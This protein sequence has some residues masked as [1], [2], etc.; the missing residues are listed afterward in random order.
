MRRKPTHTPAYPIPFTDSDDFPDLP[1]ARADYIVDILDRAVHDRIWHGKTESAYQKYDRTW[2]RWLE[3]LEFLG[4]GNDPFMDNL[5]YQRT[6]SAIVE[7]FLIRMRLAEFTTNHPGHLRSDTIREALGQL[8]E[9][10]RSDGR[11][12]PCHIAV[13]SN[14]KLRPEID[15]LLKA[16]KNMDP[17]LKQQKA[18]TPRHLIYMYESTHRTNK[19]GRTAF[20]ALLVCAAFFFACRSCEYLHVPERGR[21]KILLLGNLKFSDSTGRIEVDPNQDDFDTVAQYVSITF[22]DQKSGKK[23][24][25]RTQVKTDD[26]ILCPVKLWGKVYRRVSAIP[27][28]TDNTPV[29][30]WY[31]QTTRTRATITS[32]EIINLLRSTCDSGGGPNTFGY[33]SQD[34]GTH[35]IRSGAAMAL[36]LAH[37]SIL[38]IMILGRWSSDAFLVYIRSQVLEWTTGMSKSMIKNLDYIHVSHSVTSRQENTESLL[39]GLQTRFTYING[40]KSNPLIDAISLSH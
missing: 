19:L 30:T 10:L 23:M 6:K 26:P 32:T 25:T 13:G 36:F 12:S 8:V 21:T 40:D 4:I 34:I 14:L 9:G 5:K 38:K 39:D 33:E 31:N 1:P 7:C 27:N 29:N 28:A 3:H 17:P 35:S 37:E 11:E 18:I 15:V 20:S 22:V 2:K 16:W 24:E